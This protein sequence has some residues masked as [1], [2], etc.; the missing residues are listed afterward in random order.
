MRVGLS[1]IAI[2]GLLI[3]IS[4]ILHLLYL[5]RVAKYVGDAA[6]A[7]QFTLYLISIFVPALIGIGIYVGWRS[8]GNSPGGTGGGGSPVSRS[9]T[10]IVAGL[11][12]LLWQAWRAYL[13]H[14]LGRLLKRES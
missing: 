2:S 11:L 12:M 9:L 7:Q 3:L 8:F 14:R 10:A 1:G 5:R 13:L 4:I 6:L